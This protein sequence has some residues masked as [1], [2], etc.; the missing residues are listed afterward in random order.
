MDCKVNICPD[1]PSSAT[2]DVF[3]VTVHTSPLYLEKRLEES[4]KVLNDYKEFQ[5]LSMKL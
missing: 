4:E 5:T 2:V 3:A 1:T